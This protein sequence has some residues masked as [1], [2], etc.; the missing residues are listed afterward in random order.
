[1]CLPSVLV[2]GD[3]GVC[4]A[5]PCTRLV[6]PQLPRSNVV[7][8]QAD[9]SRAQPSNQI[10]I[11]LTATYDETNISP[12]DISARIQAFLARPADFFDLG[13]LLTSLLGVSAARKKQ[14]QRSTRSR[15]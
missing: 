15:D 4:S 12:A 8:V 13:T 9:L 6:C 11:L 14:Q 7:F 2:A 5:F 10:D 3:T 1:M